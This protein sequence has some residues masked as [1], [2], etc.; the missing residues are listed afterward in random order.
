MRRTSRSVKIIGAHE[1]LR[2]LTGDEGAHGLPFG[3]ARGDVYRRFGSEGARRPVAAATWEK[4]VWISV[5]GDG[6]GA[7][8]STITRKMRSRWV[9]GNPAFP[10]HRRSS[11]AR[12]ARASAFVVY[13]MYR[14]LRLKI[15]CGVIKK[16]SWGCL[17]LD[18]LTSRPAAARSLRALHRRPCRF[19]E[20]GRVRDA[21]IFHLTEQ[22]RPA[23]PCRW[24][25]AS[26]FPPGENAG[27]QA[28][29]G[30]RPTSRRAPGPRAS[31]HITEDR[32]PQS[33]HSSSITTPSTREKRTSSA[34]GSADRDARSTPPASCRTRRGSSRATQKLA[35]LARVVHDRR[36]LARASP[37]EV[38]LLLGA[39]FDGV[40]HEAPLMVRGEDKAVTSPRVGRMSPSTSTASV[41]GRVPARACR[42]IREGHRDPHAAP[43]VDVPLPMPMRYLAHLLTQAPELKKSKTIDGGDPWGGAQ[44]ARRH[45]RSP[46]R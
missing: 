4:V 30:G 46:C 31:T 43:G 17:G 20:H 19:I 32:E 10:P 7:R 11:R 33:R 24:L 16:R 18:R 23:S 12:S 42:S 38:L 39:Q 29:A 45:L 44:I 37:G 27:S 25:A 40:N 5:G 1:R 3:A 41:S 15:W 21:D 8:E 28:G 26:G 34:C 35:R 22:D 9:S 6:R 36:S 2:S 13:P 14:L